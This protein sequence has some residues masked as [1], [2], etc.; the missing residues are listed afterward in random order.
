MRL[1]I[2][3][4]KRSIRMKQ[5]RVVTSVERIAFPIVIGIIVNLLLPPLAPL[6]T[7]LMLGNLL[8]EVLVTDRLAKTAANEVMNVVI[9]VLTVAIG[10]TMSADKFLTG[11]TLE[12]VGLGL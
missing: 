4:E 1:L 8:K 6:I 9:V 12:I 2:T 10:S 5:M 3:R 7:M 11:S